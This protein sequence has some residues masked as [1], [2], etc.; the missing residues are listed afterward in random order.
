MAEK[1]LNTRIQLKI[2]TLE[3]WKNSTLKIKNGEVC[4][5]TVAAEAG[6]GLEEPVVMMKIGN[7]E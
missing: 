1:I 3:N 2:D 4:F 6:T 7:S 5:A